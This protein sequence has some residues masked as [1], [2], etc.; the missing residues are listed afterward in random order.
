MMRIG[1]LRLRG[2]WWAIA[3]AVA[4]G[5]AWVV[6]AGAT[7]LI[8]HLMPAGPP[9]LAGALLRRAQARSVVVIGAAIGTGVAVSLAAATMLARLGQPLDE[10]VWTLAALSVGAALGTLLAVRPSSATESH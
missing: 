1:D 5:A 6:L 9:L 3:G 8:F 4:A 2:M 7:G 10:P